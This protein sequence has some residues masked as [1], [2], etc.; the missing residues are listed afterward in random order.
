[1]I[2]KTETI[3]TEEDLIKHKTMSEGIMKNNAEE[4]AK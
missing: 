4:F 3:A 2:S 1:M